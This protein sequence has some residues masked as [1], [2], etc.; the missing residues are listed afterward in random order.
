[1]T[2]TFKNDP[3]ILRYVV[4]AH[5]KLINT[6][7][8][9]IGEDNIRVMVFFQPIPAY[10]G[11]IGRKHGGNMLGLDRLASN[12]V[13]WTGGVS[14]TSDE[15][16]LAIARTHA[17]NMLTDIKEFSRSVNGDVDFVYLN[18]ADA[19]QDPL[20]SYGSDNVQFL[21]DVAA[22]YDPSGAFQRRIP[23]GFKIDSV[24]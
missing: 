21:R 4:Q 19:S 12:A 24:V 5:E 7:G 6:L 16:S 1:M 22:K 14:I 8:E 20:G 11:R 10:L 3:E 15:L 9:S 23:G 17:N 18:Y 2:L 13:L